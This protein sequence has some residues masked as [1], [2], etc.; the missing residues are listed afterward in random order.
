M[1]AAKS[2]MGASRISQE[3]VWDDVTSQTATERVSD[4]S[5]YK[6]AME[7]RSKRAAKRKIEL[8][9]NTIGLI[10]ISEQDKLV[11]MEIH[12]NPRAFKRRIHSTLVSLEK[13][14]KK[15]I[16]PISEGKRSR[17]GRE[18]LQQL[19][20]I[21]EENVQP[22]VEVDGL[23]LDL[24]GEMQGEFVSSKFYSLVCPECGQAKSRV[25][26]CKCGFEEKAVDEFLY[27]S[28]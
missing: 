7:E 24:T 6:E 11:G 4:S 15:G 22:Q 2:R 5:K 16:K 17:K 21:D 10:A 1:K 18:V 12:R 20:S 3:A 25:A 9:D 28:F 8:P 14:I 23:L 26:V 19:V 27:A 13:E